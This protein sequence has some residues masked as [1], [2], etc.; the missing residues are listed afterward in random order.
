[1]LMDRLSSPTQET[2]IDP[3]TYELTDQ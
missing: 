2:A 3:N 1:M